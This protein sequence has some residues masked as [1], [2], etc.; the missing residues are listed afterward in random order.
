MRGIEGVKMVE[1]VY[2]GGLLRTSVN[3][4]LLPVWRSVWDGFTG[5]GQ[6]EVWVDC[7]RLN[8]GARGEHLTC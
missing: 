6:S 3:S 1:L 5:K 7:S 8:L 2:A 4:L